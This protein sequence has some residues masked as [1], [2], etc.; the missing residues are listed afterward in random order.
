MSSVIEEREP[1]HESSSAEVAFVLVEFFGEVLF[2]PAVWLILGF[3]GWAYLMLD[4]LYHLTIDPNS[5]NVGARL[6]A[7]SINPEKHGLPV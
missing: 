4:G 3:L 5:V 2:L 6:D 7:L 1:S